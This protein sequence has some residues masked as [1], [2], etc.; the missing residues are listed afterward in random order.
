M[1]ITLL[2]A[3]RTDARLVNDPIVQKAADELERL[4]AIEILARN[5]VSPTLVESAHWS[6]VRN[7]AKHCAFNHK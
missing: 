2:E 3:L 7:L 5:V 1:K 4:L 6:A